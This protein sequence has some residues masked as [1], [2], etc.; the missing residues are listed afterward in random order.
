M[1][2]ERVSSSP[3]LEKIAEL[4]KLCFDFS[5]FQND[6]ENIVKNPDDFGDIYAL[7]ENKTLI[8]Y[9]V[10]GQ[11]WL[12]ITH[13]AYITQ[14]GVYPHYRQQG[15][16]LK[17]LKV[18]LKELRTHQDCSAVHADIRQSNIA[19]QRLFKKAGFHTYCERDEPYGDEIGIRVMKT[20]RNGNKVG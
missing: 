6:F 10:Y 1:K 2:F 14:I 8:G 13:E 17:M 16:G 7:S 5:N 4:A 11:V 20:L 3:M 9:A 12:P 19:S 18:I 15:W